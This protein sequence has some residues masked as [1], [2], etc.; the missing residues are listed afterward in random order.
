MNERQKVVPLAICV[1]YFDMLYR[2]QITQQPAYDTSG[3]GNKMRA[4]DE[5]KRVGFVVKYERFAEF[6]EDDTCLL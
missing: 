1:D 2:L 4:I 3:V 5:S 6:A